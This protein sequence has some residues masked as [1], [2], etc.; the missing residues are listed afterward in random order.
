MNPYLET[1]IANGWAVFPLKD[2]SKQ[3]AVLWEKYLH[4]KPT[5]EEL[6]KLREMSYNNYAIVC[7]PVSNK[8]Y[9]LDFESIDDA[10]QFFD[11]NWETILQ[12]TWVIQTAHGGVHV[13][14]ISDQTIKREIRIFG[15]DEHPVDLMGTGGYVVAPGSSIECP[16][17]GCNSGKRG[18]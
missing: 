10:R 16:A 8:L 5:G 12:K 15:K 11:K 18:I 17:G 14:F 4:E 7:G 9:A 6:E 13:Y 1:F 3:P 2:G